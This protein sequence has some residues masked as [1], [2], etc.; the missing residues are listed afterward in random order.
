MAQQAEAGRRPA[1]GRDAAP[2]GP[3]LESQVLEA[4]PA[5]GPASGR[6]RQAGLSE[7]GTAWALWPTFLRRTL[8][9]EEMARAR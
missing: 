7:P 5:D 3:A 9:E 4:S 6:K 1:K 8:A 2:R